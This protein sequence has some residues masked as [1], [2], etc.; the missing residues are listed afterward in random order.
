MRSVGASGRLG[1]LRVTLCQGSGQHALI[2]TGSE[3]FCGVCRHD[4]SVDEANVLDDHEQDGVPFY[5]EAKV[6]EKPVLA[7]HNWPSNAELIL[8]CSRLGYLQDDWLTLDPT[9]GK[10][11]WWQ[12]WKPKQLVALNR[13]LDGSDFRKL[14]YPDNHF[15]AIAFDPPYCSKG[16]RSTSGITKMDERYG[17]DDAPA[18]PALLQ[19]LINDGLTEMHRLA[20]PGAIVLTKSMD[21]VSSGQL[22]EG[23]YLTRKHAEELGFKAVDR[24]EHVGHPGPQP[25]GRR[26]VH[27]RRNLS[28][29]YVFRKP[30]RRSNRRRAK[31]D[32][33]T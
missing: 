1:A 32:H 17:Q 5:A 29:L 16:G 18:T 12:L 4:V 25:P 22:W 14:D 7:A 20:K 28:T 6:E 26:Q 30:G 8:D 11:V 10:G 21:Y 2:F 33:Q 15:D 23:T 13:K 19:D 24:F 31:V 9:F 3:A 27:A